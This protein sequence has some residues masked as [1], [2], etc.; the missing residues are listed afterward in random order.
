MAFG[1]NLH[2]QDAVVRNIEIIG[3]A[4]RHID[5]K[6]PG[7][8]EQHPKSPLAELR[9]MRNAGT[10]SAKLAG[11]QGNPRDSNRESK[12]I[13]GNPRSPKSTSNSAAGSAVLVRVRSRHDEIVLRHNL[14]G[15][16]A[17]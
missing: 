17:T 3:E 14:R 12:A 11:I 2:V 9:G 5:R 13:Q 6:A 16:P 10:I 4:V 15:A 8:T 7:F 1:K